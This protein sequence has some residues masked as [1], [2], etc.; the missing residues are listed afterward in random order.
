MRWMRTAFWSAIPP[1]RMASATAAAGARRT[2]SQAGN[3][4]LSVAKARSEFTS[5]VCCERTVATTSSSGGSAG[6]G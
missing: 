2:S 6:F 5:E 3:R 1:L 4:R